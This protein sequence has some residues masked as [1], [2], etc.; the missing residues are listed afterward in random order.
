MPYGLVPGARRT[1][2]Q[3]SAW[4]TLCAANTADSGV[5]DRKAHRQMDR[6]HRTIAEARA[7]PWDSPVLN[8]PAK[9]STVPRNVIACKKA[10]PFVEPPA[11]RALP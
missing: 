8:V 9:G 7:S 11:V 5:P 2:A 6:A 3:L 10:A 1:S 4:E